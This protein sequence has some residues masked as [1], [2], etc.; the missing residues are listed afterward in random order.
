MKIKGLDFLRVYAIILVICYHYFPSS[1]SGGFL[2]VNILFVISGFLISYHLI[3]ELFEN[4]KIDY[5][6]FY[7]KRFL[8]IFPALLLYLNL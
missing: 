8:R 3:N 7:R 5:K 1:M 2:G 4:G 6:K